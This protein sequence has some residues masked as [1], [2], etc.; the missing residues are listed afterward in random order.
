M[1][2]PTP[3]LSNG[4]ASGLL[5][6]EPQLEVLYNTGVQSFVRRDH[7]TTQA[8]LNLLL[9][10]LRSHHRRHGVQW[11][12]PAEAGAGNDEELERW[13]IKTLK[14][15][16]S[17]H[18]S[19]YTDP[20]SIATKLPSDLRL[21]LPPSKPDLILEHVHSLC[22]ETYF[23]SPSPEPRLL[24]PSLVATLLLASLKL[25][26]PFAHHLAES[27][28]ALLPDSLILAISPYCRPEQKA[29]DIHRVEAAR[30]GYLKVV[31]LFVGEVLAREGEW[32]MARGFLDN[33][34]VMSSKRKEVGHLKSYVLVKANILLRRF[35]VISDRRKLGPALHLHRQLVQLSSH[36]GPLRHTHPHPHLYHPHPHQSRMGDHALARR[37]RALVSVPLVLSTSTE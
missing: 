17:S 19:L 13:L 7:P 8:T 12:E 27:W 14:L 37:A 21:F 10:L 3:H 1:T 5:E 9:E 36:L 22:C 28:L 33:E 35:T 15:V 26:L 34:T 30:E 4:P 20:P 11:Y 24:P 32:E 6:S 16:I 25:S 2:V 29:T 23:T 18:A 31:E